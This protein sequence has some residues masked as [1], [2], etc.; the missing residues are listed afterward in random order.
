MGLQKRSRRHTKPFFFGLVTLSQIT[1]SGI[2]KAPQVRSLIARRILN[3]FLVHK[4]VVRKS[5]HLQQ[6][7]TQPLQRLSNLRQFRIQ[8]NVCR[9]AF[10]WKQSIP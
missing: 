5:M 8:F 10:L 6:T 7:Y 4:P 1:A 3:H 9:G 2:S